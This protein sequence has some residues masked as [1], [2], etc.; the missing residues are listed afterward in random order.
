MKKR[1]TD[2]GRAYWQNY[3]PQLPVNIMVS[4]KT[5]CEP[6]YFV[7]RKHSSISAFEYI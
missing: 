7:Q 4:G 2:N 6:D 3:D 1:K 5:V